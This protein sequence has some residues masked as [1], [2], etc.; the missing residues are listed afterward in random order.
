VNPAPHLATTH[1][2]QRRRVDSIAPATLAIDNRAELELLALVDVG[3]LGRGGDRAELEVLAL[4]IDL[5]RGSCLRYVG[6]EGQ[7]LR[8]IPDK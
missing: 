2:S 1:G 6:R 5:Q 3:E 8:L 4:H 7:P